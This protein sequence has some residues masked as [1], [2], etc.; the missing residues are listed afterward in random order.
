MAGSKMDEKNENL[1]FREAEHP[2]HLVRELNLLRKSEEFCDVKILVGSRSFPAHRCILSSAC[3]YFRLMFSSGL[4]ESHKSEVEI[5]GISETIF[6]IILEFIY[7]GNVIV[8]MDDTQDLLVAANMLQIVSLKEACSIHLQNRI[9]CT[10]CIGLFEFA[11]VY[12][13]QELKRLAKLFI[14]ENFVKVFQ[15]EN[16]EFLELECDKLSEFLS[17]EDLKVESEEEILKIALQWLLHDAESRI[18]QASVILGKIRLP[19]LPFEII[20]NAIQ[21]ART[22]NEQGKE[23]LK[24]HSAKVEQMCKNIKKL[25]LT[26]KYNISVRRGTMK[27]IY[28][29]GGYRSPQGFSWLSGDCLS[30]NRKFD[31]K[32]GRSKMLITTQCSEA[33]DPCS[34]SYW[35]QY[36][37]LWRRM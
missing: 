24:D 8:E 37:R 20:S 13:C 19:L 2:Q 21:K 30:S 4:K 1:S 7:T 17:E 14:V 25:Q 33:R 12:D 34:C 27:F 16:E 10:N 32:S 36:L 3:S 5:F 22:E 11:G 28:I 9:D 35:W 18:K 23:E 6:D 29:V 15:K 26:V 31:L